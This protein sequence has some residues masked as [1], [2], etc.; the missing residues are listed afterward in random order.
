M[1]FKAMK[2]WKSGIKQVEN[3]RLMCD[4]KDALELKAATTK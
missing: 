3:M 1:H 4:L 2:D